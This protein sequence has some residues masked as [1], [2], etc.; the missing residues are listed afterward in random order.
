MF[1]KMTAALAA[2]TAISSTAFAAIID[3]GPLTLGV[4]QGIDG[5]YVNVVTGATGTSAATRPV[6]WDLNPYQVSGTTNIGFFWPTTPATSSG[7]VSTGGLYD[8]LAAGAV[9]GPG[10]TFITALTAPAAV[11]FQSAGSKILGFRFFNEATSAINFGYALKTKSTTAGGGFPAVITRI[12]YEDT[13]LPITVAGAGVS[14]GYSSVPAPG[15]AVS[16]SA[17][18]TA[19]LVIT[20]SGAAGAGPLNVTLSGLTGVVSAL[21]LTGAIAQGANATFAIRC[22]N[23]AATAVTQTLS[24]AHNGVAPPATPVTH[25]VT[26]AGAAPVAAVVQAPALGSFGML[27]LMLGFLGLGVFAARRYS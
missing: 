8:N 22:A 20:N 23:T 7:G 16:L 17:T 9:V 26:C 18:G 10:S 3:S 4:M 14:A 11:N 6:G 1:K 13:G 21:P 24:I 19:N 27:G 2:F 12:F 25:V 5:I 15:T